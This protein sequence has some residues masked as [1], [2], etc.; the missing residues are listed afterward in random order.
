MEQEEQV[1]LDERVKQLRER[2]DEGFN[3]V[4]KSITEF[5]VTL[6]DLSQTLS[7]TND[8]LAK[9]IWQQEKDTK[10][11]EEN[12]KGIDELGERIK[13]NEKFRN[14]ITAQFKILKWLIGLFGIET[15]L[16]VIEWISRF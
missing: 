15:L 5:G 12:K 1:R 2:I 16:Q 13:D 7:I 6:K 4:T 14:D 8:K 11:I 3:H 9:Q 10:K